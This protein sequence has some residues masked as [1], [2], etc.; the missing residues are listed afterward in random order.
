M[1]HT[2][3]LLDES[4]EALNLKRG[5]VVIDATLGN[6]GH[7]LAIANKIGKNGLL[8][9]IDVD[10]GALSEAKK[11]L[12]ATGVPHKLIRGNFRDLKELTEQVG[13]STA[14]AVLA[15]LGWR[16]EQFT[17][18]SGK[19]LSFEADEPLHMT[20]GEPTDYPFRAEDIVNEWSEET[21][22]NIL[23][24]YGQERYARRIASSIVASRKKERIST[25]GQ[26]S[27]LIKQAVP[28]SYRNGRIHP[29]TR[30]FQALRIAVNDEL[31]ALDK[32]L[33]QG[34]EILSGGGRLAV[35]SFH[36]LEDRKVKHMFR[37]FVHDQCAVLVNKKPITATRQEILA[38]PRSRSA[39]LRIIEK[40]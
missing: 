2:P 40:I 37:D 13:V 33:P 18:G 3:V 12:S 11:C 8:V 4:I 6:G 17:V 7:S 24:G 21:I 34:F 25:S 32:F 29:A 20:L 10:P 15:D 35:I 19:G 31:G 27:G 1:K 38:N 39:K 14:N 28:V 9:G 22:A 16:T 5:D 26:L 36:S 23:Y 30:S